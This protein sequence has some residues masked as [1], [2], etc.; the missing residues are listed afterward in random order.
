MEEK[1]FHQEQKS[2]RYAPDGRKMLP[3][4]APGRV[5]RANRCKKHPQA[6]TAATLQREGVILIIFC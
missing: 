2:G 3:S 1:R 4:G 5:N 6:A